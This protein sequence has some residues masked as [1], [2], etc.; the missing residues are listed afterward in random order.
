MES[1]LTSLTRRGLQCAPSE[2]GELLLQIGTLPHEIFAGYHEKAGAGGK[3]AASEKKIL[4]DVF[5]KGDAYFR[6]GDL[7]HRTADGYFYFADRLG[8]TFRW[9]SENVATTQVSEAL[10]AVVGEANVYGVL[11]PSHE[12]RAGCAAIPRASGG[13]GL[14]LDKLAAHVKVALPK[15]AQPLFLRMVERVDVNGTSKQLKVA[16]RNEGVDPAVVKD[17]VF[18]LKGGKYVR[19]EVEDWEALKAGRVKL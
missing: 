5:V 10:G 1:V 7:L 2:P 13:A 16:L 12:G 18:W 15:Y 4:R 19:F 17:E 9:K 14:D 8:D 11:V 3:K 6:T